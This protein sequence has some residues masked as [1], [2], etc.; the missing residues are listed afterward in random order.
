MTQ[1]HGSMITFSRPDGKQV[2]GYLAKPAKLEGAPAIVV[3]QE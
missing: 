3:I 1:A 2:Q